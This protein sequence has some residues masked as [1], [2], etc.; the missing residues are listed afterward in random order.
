MV[1]RTDT[2]PERRLRQLL[3]HKGYRFRKDYR[4]AGVHV[5]IAFTRRKVAILV[6]G[7]FWHGC[8]EHWVLPSKNIPYWTAKIGSVRARDSRND[9]SLAKAN[10]RA[11]R[12]WEHELRMNAPDVLSRIGQELALADSDQR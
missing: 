10:W 2:F 9:E 6:D 4:V 1:R 7:C 12:I 3:W 11:V 5:D 8:P